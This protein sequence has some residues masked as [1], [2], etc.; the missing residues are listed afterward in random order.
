MR[1]SRIEVDLD[2]KTGSNQFHQF[3]VELLGEDLR[4]PLGHQLGPDLEE[5]DDDTRQDED[6]GVDQTQVH[7]VLRL[8]SGRGHRGP[9]L[10]LKY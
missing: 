1:L 8:E 4:L 10:V 3:L 7:R 5:G 2:E 9:Q 6:D